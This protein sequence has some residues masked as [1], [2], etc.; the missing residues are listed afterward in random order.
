MTNPTSVGFIS[1]LLRG[2]GL[3][4]HL[5]PILSFQYP[6]KLQQMLGIIVIVHTQDQGIFVAAIVRE[7]NFDGI[8]KVAIVLKHQQL[9]VAGGK[10]K[11]F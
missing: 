7:K 9:L 8:V 5:L 6:M 11:Q 1:N 4:P 2:N 3:L 10:P